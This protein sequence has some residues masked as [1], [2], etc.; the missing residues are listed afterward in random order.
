[1]KAILLGF[2]LVTG[3]FGQ[4]LPYPNLGKYHCW[5]VTAKPCFFPNDTLWEAD[6]NNWEPSKREV[7]LYNESTTD[8]AFFDSIVIKVDT[9]VFE[10]VDGG[11]SVF[12]VSP[13]YSTTSIVFS[14]PDPRSVTKTP[15]GFAKA[16]RFFIPPNE[17]KQVRGLR[18]DRC[19][20]CQGNPS[21]P[22]DR[23]VHAEIMFKSNLSKAVLILIGW[24][25]NPSSVFISPLL[26]ITSNQTPNGVFFNSLGRPLGASHGSNSFA[27]FGSTTIVFPVPNFG[28]K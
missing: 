2:F 28:P 1:M 7:R 3:I 9:L 12:G 25:Y 17:Y 8:T 23:I 16:A 5:N 27:P 22:N 20:N 18:L 19:M 6:D 14:I 26:P 4:N 15:E 24:Y 13:S 21:R 10:T 11:L